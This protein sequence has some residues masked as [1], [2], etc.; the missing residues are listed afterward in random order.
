MNKDLASIVLSSTNRSAGEL[1]SLI[2]M[3]KEVCEDA[4]YQE[5]K[6]ALASIISDIWFRVDKRILEQFPDLEREMNDR[7]NKYGRK[8]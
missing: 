2:P 6:M 4:E 1:A 3:L 8:F 5:L 7:L